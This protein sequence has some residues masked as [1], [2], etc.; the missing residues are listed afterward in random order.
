MGKVEGMCVMNK[1]SN[2]MSDWD[3]KLVPGAII[4]ARC[5]PPEGADDGTWHVFE[6]TCMD[7]RGNTISRYIEGFWTTAEGHRLNSRWW[8]YSHPVPMDRPVVDPHA[9]LIGAIVEAA[10]EFYQPRAGS[11]AAAYDALKF[12]IENLRAAMTPPGP[13]KELREAWEEAR[14]VQP[15][16]A[17]ARLDKAI[18]A[19]IVALRKDQTP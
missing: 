18:K 3:G 19:A 4:P 2:L 15:A 7:G 17:G 16:A 8:S 11:T 10:L 1:N 13:A 5:E 14:C 9:A 12:A 6:P